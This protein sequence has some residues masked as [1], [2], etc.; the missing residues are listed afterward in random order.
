MTHHDYKPI[1][2]VSPVLVKAAHKEGTKSVVR[3]DSVNF[4]VGLFG[5][6]AR[7]PY[8]LDSVLTQVFRSAIDLVFNAPY[9]T[10]QGFSDNGKIESTVLSQVCNSV[11]LSL[12][13]ANIKEP[14]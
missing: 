13:N 9:L 10:F 4:L 14:L 3:P 1:N 2:E 11:H 8:Y 6:F 5:F 12:L 7:C